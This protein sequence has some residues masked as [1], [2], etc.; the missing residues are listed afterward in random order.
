MEKTLRLYTYVDGGINDAPFPSMESQIEIGAFRYDAKRMGGAPTITASVNY[1]SCLDDEWTDNVYA[2]FNGERYYLKQIPTSSYNNSSAM[3]KHDIELV[4]ERVALDNVYF[5]DVVTEEM[6]ENDKPVSNSTKVTFF[7]DVREFASRLQASLE[8]SAIDYSVVVDTGVT[9][10]EKL[11]SFDNQFFS[12]VLQEIYNTYEV[13]YYFEGKTIHIGYSKIGEELPTFAYGVDDALVSVTKN[14]A[15]Y[16]IVNRATGTGSS[17]N[18]PF[19]YPNNSPKG[20]IIPEVNNNFEATIVDH[21]LYANNIELG[22]VLRKT[23]VGYSNLVSTHNGDEFYSG[24]TFESDFKSGLRSAVFAFSFDAKDAGDLKVTFDPSIIGFREPNKE[25]DT[26]ARVEV[27]WQAFLL[28]EGA[29]P[30]RPHG[31]EILFHESNTQHR[32]QATVSIPIEKAGVGY[33]AMINV[34]FTPINNYTNTIGAVVYEASFDLGSESGWV[35]EEGKTVHLESVGLSTDGRESVGDTITQTLVEYVNTSKVLMPFKYRQTRGKDRFYNATNDTYE[36]VTFNNPFVEGRP[37]EHIITVEDIKPSIKGMV[38]NGLE[39]DK[40]EAFA[41]DVDDNDE[42]YEDEEG[43]VFFKH[44]YFFAKLKPLGF[45]LFKHAIEQQPMTISFTSGACGACNFE[46][47]VD[48]E[49]Q[50]NTVQVDANGDLIYEDGRV[51]CGAEGSGQGEVQPQP[52]QQDTTS[53]SVWIALRKEEDTYGILMPQHGKHEPTIDDTFVILGINLPQSYI[54]SAEKKLEAEIIKY[55]Q[56][57]NDDKFTFS[58]GFS[59]IY[60]AENEEVLNALN[61]NSK[62]KITYNG[63]T[64]ELFVSSFSYA[65]SEGDTL[66]EIR[67]ELDETLKTSQNALQNAISE[68]KSTL[69]EAINEVASEVAMQRRTYVSK[70]VDDTALG[71]VNFSKGVKFGEGGKV[72]ILD[73]N[74]AKLTI[75]YLEVTKKASFTSL[76]IK[77]KTHAGGQILVTPASLNCGEVEEF[78]DFYRC[79]FQ[80]KG[81]GGDEIFNQFA[82]ND[83]AICQTF[84]AWGSRYYWRLVVGV[85][86]D[87]I[88]LSKVDCDEGS[89]IP[90]AGDKIIQMGN[91]VEE[92]RQNAIVIAAYGE[93]T[94][95]IVQ[96]KG[97]SNYELPNSED[98]ERITTLLSPTRNVLTGQVRMT[99]GSSGLE[100]FL[101]WQGVE[102]TIASMAYIQKA[103]QNGDTIVTGG[104][105]QS[106]ILMLG[107]VDENGVYHVMSGTNG[108]YDEN[109]TGGGI[110]AWYGGEMSEDLAKTVLRFDGSGFFANKNITW[111]NEGGASFANGKI[112]I[113]K[114]GALIFSDNIAFGSEENETVASIIE[115]LSTLLSFFSLEGDELTTNYQLR[116]KNSIIADG[117][118]SSGGAGT[119]S[120]PEGGQTSG[121]YKMYTH[122]QET[123]EKVWTIVHGLGKY[124]N[125][126]VVDSTHELC[127][128]DVKYPN[129]DTVTIEFGAPFGGMAYLD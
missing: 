93:N 7:G 63:K 25:I 91:R 78:E 69:G 99:A 42:T 77:E 89:G 76:E 68:V 50:K 15:N 2:M 47:A 112:T 80:T 23:N 116:V 84:N 92:A 111:D 34:G 117:E 90:E 12:N 109:A 52:E 51:L 58:I 45:N 82:V 118:V 29:N 96:Y 41:Y 5:F 67:V 128:G 65:M 79:Y 17:E 100:N 22:G 16:K 8:Y 81:E 39:I 32:G 13:P 36:G 103:I 57:N 31:N 27:R 126:K 110:A 72:E 26:T 55:L 48:E 11:I 120:D 28:S 37:K 86:E 106:G 19:Y 121:E 102:N 38:V 14:N 59:R 44:P 71:V 115:K 9:S 124:P 56:D 20:N 1:P 70:T 3:Y 122:A 46:I 85:G 94:P 114:E 10:E 6:S 95:Y 54:E 98:D 108:V 83:Q 60:F 75:E 119:E 107:Y 87:Y 18:L 33:I 49:S 129:I 123:A 127:Y 30:E 62:I 73:N 64:Y 88:D 104:L 125:V 4:S 24:Q 35:N 53:R 105:I 97:I 101:E 66:P 40:F 61:E 113:T 74:S 21:E 43:N